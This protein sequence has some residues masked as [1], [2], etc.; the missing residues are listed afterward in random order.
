MAQETSVRRLSLNVPVTLVEAIQEISATSGITLTELLCAGL[1]MVQ[2]GYQA[3]AKGGRII[4]TNQTGQPD[5]VLVLPKHGMQAV[6]LT[7]GT[8]AVKVDV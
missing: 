1:Q 5:Q 4:I 7:T 2:A 3:E 8:Q 6:S